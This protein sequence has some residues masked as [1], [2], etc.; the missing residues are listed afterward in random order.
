M[1]PWLKFLSLKSVMSCPRRF[2]LV[3][4]FCLMSFFCPLVC[5]KSTPASLAVAHV[6]LGDEVP[7][8]EDNEDPAHGE[9]HDGP[10]VVF[11]GLLLRVG[12]GHHFGRGGRGQISIDHSLGNNAGGVVTE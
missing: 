3:S 1:N 7:H 11:V 10:V 12:G 6:S 2:G 8:H 4:H 5:I 9:E